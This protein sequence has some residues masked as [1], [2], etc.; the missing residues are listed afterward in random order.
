MALAEA[1]PRYTTCL[2]PVGKG[3]YVAVKS[4]G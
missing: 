4:T 1:D 2:V 3:E